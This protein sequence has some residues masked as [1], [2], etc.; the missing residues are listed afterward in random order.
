MTTNILAPFVKTE[1]SFKF[2][3]NGRVF[4]MNNNIIT[5]TESIESHLAEAIAAFESFEFSTNTIKWFHGASK[6]TYS[7][8]E[9]T[10]SEG[11]VVIEN[12]TKHVLSAGLVRYENRATANLFESLP[13]MIDN[14]VSLDFAA[15]FEGKNNI[16]N[17]F[18]IEEK[19]YVSR[20]NTSNK[21]AKFFEATNANAA[22][23]FVT[24]QTGLSAATFLNELV[25]GQAQEIAQNEATIKSYQDMVA[26]L[27]DQRGL[28]AEADKSIPEIK[29]AD[30]LI[31][32]EITTWETK[33]SE[34]QA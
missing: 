8:T 12:F 13:A 21:I 15:T 3:V 17:L 31:N 30:S 6:F 32:E 1:N 5:E 11:D 22:V 14:F 9:N 19:V 2:Y 4:E 33:I 27:K 29:A 25:T 20:F 23:D 24:E 7:L 10:F 18:K 26:F 16:V 28:L 34:L